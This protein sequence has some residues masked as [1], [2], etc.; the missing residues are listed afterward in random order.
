MEERLKLIVSIIAI[1]GGLYGAWKVIGKSIKDYFFRNYYYHMQGFHI[2]SDIQRAFGVDAGATILKFMSSYNDYKSETNLR[3]D[4][5][6][7][8]A[9][10]GIY[11][12]AV[13]GECIYANTTLCRMFGMSPEDMK[14]FGWVKPLVDPEAEYKHWKFSVE[15]SL[16]YNSNYEVMRDGKVF[17]YHTEAEPKRT[18][19]GVVIGYVGIVKPV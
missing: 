10:I 17:M 1:I 18:A 6:E 11:V 12:C 4:I 8:D 16:P 9:N 5:L 13:T 3:L 7:T 14:G 19:D 15:N 2:M